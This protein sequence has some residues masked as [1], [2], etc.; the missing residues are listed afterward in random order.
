[1]YIWHR[2]GRRFA[3]TLLVV[4]SAL[5]VP[6]FVLASLSLS[7]TPVPREFKGWAAVFTTGAHAPPRVFLTMTPSTPGGYG[8]HPVVEYGITVC[9]KEAFD[10]VLVLAGNARIRVP[11]PGT[12]PVSP[13]SSP[14]SVFLVPDVT[15]LVVEDAASGGAADVAPV[16]V[17]RIHSP[18]TPCHTAYD[19]KSTPIWEGRTIGVGGPLEGPTV[20]QGFAPFG[21]W[22]VR[23][24][25][26]WP[27]LGQVP[28]FDPIDHG[29]FRLGDRL[30]GPW[31]RPA[32]SYYGVNLGLLDGKALVDFSRPE[33]TN[34]LEALAWAG[35]KP[36]AAK[37]RVTNVDNLNHWQ[38]VSTAAGIWLGIGGSILAALAL[39]AVR[40]DRRKPSHTEPAELIERAEPRLPVQR[41]REPHHHLLLGLSVATLAVILRRARR[42]GKR[43]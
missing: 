21:L 6:V 19:P 37:A 25:Q 23:Q 20:H 14:G 42:T 34:G 35:S 41:Q 39:E 13:E 4:L 27:Y 12:Q 9:G 32:Q 3:M 22:P 43:L 16:Q 18:S 1:M 17:F 38:F 5:S 8:A 26:S 31:F 33:A 40:R 7:S 10:G 28:V 15:H 30:P 2:F 29:A 24:A 36:F 11:D